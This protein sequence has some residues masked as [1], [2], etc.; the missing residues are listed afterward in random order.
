MSK[1]EFHTCD[2]CGDYPAI[3]RWWN[4]TYMCSPCARKSFRKYFATI[5]S[6]V[7]VAIIIVSCV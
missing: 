2:V 4:G 6:I 1:F 7:I 5:T 3:W